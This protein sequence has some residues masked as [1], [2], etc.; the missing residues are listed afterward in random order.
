MLE[1]NAESL[2]MQTSGFSNPLPPPN[3]QNTALLVGLHFKIICCQDTC[4]VFIELAA[5]VIIFFQLNLEK[6]NK[7]SGFALKSFREE[8]LGYTS[9]LLQQ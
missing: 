2:E 3:T 7:Y 4:V 9:W 5:E 6:G 8:L 1:V